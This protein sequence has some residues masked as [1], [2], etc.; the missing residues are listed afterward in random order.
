MIRNQSPDQL[1]DFR[2][3]TY[4][5]AAELLKVDKRTIR[6]RVA[7]G[8]YSAYGDGPG[9]RILFRSIVADVQQHSTGAH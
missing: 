1:D 2:M 3:L 4:A 7:K 8:R 6:R 5:E 9:K